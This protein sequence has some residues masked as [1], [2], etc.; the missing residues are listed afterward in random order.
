MEQ[1]WS[2]PGSSRLPVVFLPVAQKGG[3]GGGMV[4]QGMAQGNVP[5]PLLPR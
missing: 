2:P 3:T 1:A 4:A 5:V